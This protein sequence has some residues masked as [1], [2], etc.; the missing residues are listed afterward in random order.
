MGRLP[1]H[2]VPSGAVSTPGIRTS[3][4]QAAEAD[5][6]HLTIVPLGRPLLQLI[7]INMFLTNL[8]RFRIFGL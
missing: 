8:I 6:A 7:L 3:E 2:G 4:P 1:Q 5:C